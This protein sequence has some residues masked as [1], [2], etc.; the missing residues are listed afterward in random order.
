M[1]PI[2]FSQLEFGEE[3]IP[4][5]INILEKCWEANMES[6]QDWLK[7]DGPDNIVAEVLRGKGFVSKKKAIVPEVVGEGVVYF[8]TFTVPQEEAAP[9]DTV[10]NMAQVAISSRLFNIT[11]YVFSIEKGSGENWHV[12]M[13]CRCLPKNGKSMLL[14][15]DKI[16]KL[17][18]FTG[19]RID[20]KKVK[21]TKK[22]FNDTLKYV[23]KDAG[24]YPEVNEKYE[25]NVFANFELP[26][27]EETYKFHKSQI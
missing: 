5:D 20:F 25:A 15:Y 24:K 9:I 11:K 8:I 22:D 1:N 3:N 13:L 17:K 23:L 16:K 10:Y 27:K 26:I 18:S 7:T 21:P 4:H 12:H 19:R 14:P 6:F 2:E